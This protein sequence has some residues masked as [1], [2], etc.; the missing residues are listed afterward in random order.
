MD[1]TPISRWSLISLAVGQLVEGTFDSAAALE[2]L[3]NI[4]KSRVR[5]SVPRYGRDDG[6]YCFEIE[7]DKMTLKHSTRSTVST[8]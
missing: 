2:L 1:T 7:S 8:R 3:L 5:I 4:W 6:A